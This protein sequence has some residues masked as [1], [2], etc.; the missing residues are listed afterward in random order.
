MQNEVT[1]LK[2]I[3]KEYRSSV[4]EQA[5]RILEDPHEAE[6]LTQEV[7]LNVFRDLDDFREEAQLGTWIHR[8]TLNKGLTRRRKKVLNFI[9]LEDAEGAQE[10]IDDD[11]NPEEQYLKREANARL[12]WLISKL[13]PKEATAISLSCYGGKS[14]EEI[15]QIMH[16][17]PG[18]V[19][20]ILHRGRFHLHALHTGRKYKENRK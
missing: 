16:L 20:V 18:S 5:L 10:L 17:R 19:A 7:F 8:I 1:R 11:I 14:S 3:F 13:R 6:E 2:E 4:Y 15:A 9:S 12:S